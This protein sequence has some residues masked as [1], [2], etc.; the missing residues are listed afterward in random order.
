[1]IVTDQ[2]AEVLGR[3]QEL[4]LSVLSRTC[5]YEIKGSSS[6]EVRHRELN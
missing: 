2:G 4:S 6:T 3:R 5:Q 1:M